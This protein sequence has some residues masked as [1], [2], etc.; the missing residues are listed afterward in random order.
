MSLEM[1]G[2]ALMKAT[3][4]MATAVKMKFLALRGLVTGL[5]QNFKRRK[6]VTAYIVAN[7]TWPVPS[8]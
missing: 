7:R 2:E 3:I 8:K 5:S 4:L 6:M 1:S